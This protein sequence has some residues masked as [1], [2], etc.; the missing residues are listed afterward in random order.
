MLGHPEVFSP[1][2]SSPPQGF[3]PGFG[4]AGQAARNRRPNRYHN[5][6]TRPAFS[7]LSKH[8]KKVVAIA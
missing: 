5:I 1:P 7:L 8:R 4:P 2:P 3:I 6:I